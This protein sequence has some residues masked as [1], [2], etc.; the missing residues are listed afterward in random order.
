[1]CSFI[2]L[3]FAIYSYTIWVIYKLRFL[4]LSGKSLDLLII[5]F[6]V[7]CSPRTPWYQAVVI[8]IFLAFPR[9]NWITM[10]SCCKLVWFLQYNFPRSSW[11]FVP[12]PALSILYNHSECEWCQKMC[13]R[14]KC[15]K[16]SIM[17]TTALK[18]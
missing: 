14:S 4:W 16:N 18:S 5:R 10:K 9:H 2:L 7:W 6:R 17:F 11:T 13:F 3:L 1:M 8:L 12:C 15:S